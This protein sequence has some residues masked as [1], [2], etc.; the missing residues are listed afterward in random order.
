MDDAFLK[1]TCITMNE[2]NNS[3]PG[4]T[5]DYK[6]CNQLLK[7]SLGNADQTKDTFLTIHVGRYF[8]GKKNCFIISLIQISDIAK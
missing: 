7:G 3:Y 8:T 1:S 5:N 2:T 6:I 4:T